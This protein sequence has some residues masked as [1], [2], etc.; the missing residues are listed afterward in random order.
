MNQTEP[1][2]GQIE[3][4]PA[5]LG[6]HLVNA[7]SQWKSPSLTAQVGKPA[8]DW[9]ARDVIYNRAQS[10]SIHFGDVVA[11]TFGATWCKLTEWQIRFWKELHLVHAKNGLIV[12]GMFLDFKESI[13]PYLMTHEIR[14]SFHC[15]VA[16]EKIKWDYGIN[17]TG[18][19]PF[20]AL[21]DRQGMLNSTWIGYYP[22]D[23]YD[24]AIK[25]LL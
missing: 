15:C 8:P 5:T 13:P 18:R 9:A 25:P 16:T 3:T 7:Y 14:S 10:K 21:V 17:P 6:S 20:M 23:S 2:I 4:R 1:S 12:I 11:I 19:I 22:K 24:A